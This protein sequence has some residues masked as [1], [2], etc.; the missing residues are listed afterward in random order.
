MGIGSVGEKERTSRGDW[1][2]QAVHRYH[3]GIDGGRVALDAISTSKGSPVKR[4]SRIPY[5]GVAARDEAAWDEAA[6]DEAARDLKGRGFT[7]GN[8]EGKEEVLGQDAF[9]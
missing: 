4:R 3:E 1:V 5:N 2:G 9:G 6:R 7:G 8:R